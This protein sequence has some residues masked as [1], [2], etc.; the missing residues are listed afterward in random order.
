MNNNKVLNEFHFLSKIINSTIEYWPKHKTSIDRLI[1][2]LKKNNM[3]NFADNMSEEILKII[4]PNLISF[5]KSYKLMCI[6]MISSEIYFRKNKKYNMSSTNEVYKKLYSN[7]DL[8]ESYMNGLLLAHVLWFH[9]IIPYNT[10]LNKFLPIL[11]DNYKYLE[12]GP[13]HGLSLSRA[14]NDSRSS[15]IVG[16]DISE[17]SIKQ[18]YKNNKI[19]GGDK[20]NL[21]VKD[22]SSK[23][24]SNN[25]Y[26]FDGIVVNQVLEIVNDPIL[27]LSNIYSLLAKNGKVFITS[28]VQSSAPDHIRRWNSKEDIF[29][30]LRSSGLNINFF[31]E[32][33]QNQ[34]LKNDA[35][36]LTI[37]ASKD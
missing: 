20:I 12:I 32:T 6:N 25:S 33:H 7:T 16:W 22:I 36:S 23:V 21:F 28:P 2:S 27:T 35:L 9:H 19:L 14:S 24:S 17:E 18:T 26:L 13:G 1:I 31:D 10:F 29:D 37:I 3:I 15:Y 11:P 5:I 34:K 8:M 30:L 4:G